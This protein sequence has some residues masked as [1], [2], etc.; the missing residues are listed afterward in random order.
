GVPLALR[1]YLAARFRKSRPSFRWQRLRR[2]LHKWME[3]HRRYLEYHAFSTR[4]VFVWA[5]IV[6]YAAVARGALSMGRM[7]ARVWASFRQ[8]VSKAEPVQRFRAALAR[9]LQAGGNSTTI[10]WYRLMEEA[11]ATRLV[12]KIKTL[13]D[14]RAWYCPTAFWP[15]FNQ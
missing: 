4:S 9:L 10:R 6:A 1:L 13:Q 2:R 11:E 3:G 12:A 14:V 7:L 15:S 5:G 8:S